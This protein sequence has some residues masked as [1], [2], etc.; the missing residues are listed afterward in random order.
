[1]HRVV[2]RDAA[3]SQEMT[4]TR[5]RRPPNAR[6]IAASSSKVEPSSASLTEAEVSITTVTRGGVRRRLGRT[7]SGSAA[8]RRGGRP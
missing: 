1:M 4:L 5:S 6:A 8:A 7:A 2:A 3:A